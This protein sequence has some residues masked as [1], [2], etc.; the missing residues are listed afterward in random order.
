MFLMIFN[1]DKTYISIGDF[2]DVFYKIKFKGIKFVLSKFIK[3]SNESRISSKWDVYESESDFW[4]VPEIK[5]SWNTKIS[6]NPDVFYEEYVC[7]KYLQNCS[8]ISLL[9]IGC[10]E[11]GHER[12]FA[13]H[14]NFDEIIGVDISIGSIE[15]ARKM[16]LDAGLKITYHCNDFFRLDF[17]KAKFDV[18]LFNASLHHFDEIETFLK[19]HIVPLLKE[20][21]IVVVNEFCGPNRLQWRKNQLKEANDLLKELPVVFKTR[22]DGKSI[23]C[24]VYRPGLFRMLIVDPSEAPDS[25]NLAQALKNTFL[26]LEETKLGWNILHILLKDIAH[27]FLKGDEI[28]KKLIQELIKKEDQFVAITNENDAIFGVYQNRKKV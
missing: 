19:T 27:N 14:S 28:T 18:I 26:V 11:G 4:I 1:I 23:K 6:S 8:N 9:S 17:S 16:A 7:K 13:K 25:A 2:V 21:G 22:I 12:E 10:G 5:Q 20:N 3:I 24:K 15:K